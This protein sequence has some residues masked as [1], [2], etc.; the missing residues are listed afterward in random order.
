M[1]IEIVCA[2]CDGHLGRPKNEVSDAD[3]RTALCQRDLAGIEPAGADDTP[4][5]PAALV[6]NS[7]VT[8]GAARCALRRP[9]SARA[10]P[11]GFAGAGSRQP[12]E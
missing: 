5:L 9:D 12:V 1:R 7:R 6:P 8:G 2:K 10:S 4:K 11:E 3:R